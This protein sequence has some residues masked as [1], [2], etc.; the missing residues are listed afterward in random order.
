MN[1]PEI[2]SIQGGWHEYV[3]A[4]YEIYQKEIAFGKLTFNQLPVKCQYRPATN[5]KG[6]GFW[7]V[8][9]DGN[10]EEDRIPDLRRCERI[11]WIA[12]TIKNAFEDKRIKWWKN[13]RGRDIRVVLW[14]E[15]FD[16]AVIL[17][18]RRD[19]YLLKTAYLLTPHRKLIFKKEYEDY[20]KVKND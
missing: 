19:Y 4:L 16:F 2:F 10:V 9:S 18:E 3:E 13:K 7:H 12:W 17:A 1:F 6:Y 5:N 14:I 8:I 20:W 11:H 15:E